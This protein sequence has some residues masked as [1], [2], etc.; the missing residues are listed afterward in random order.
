M[1]GPTNLPT[2]GLSSCERKEICRAHV[3]VIFQLLFALSIRVL[4]II[5]DYTPRHVIYTTSESF[6]PKLFLPMHRKLL[7]P[8]RK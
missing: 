7:T 2:T 4:Y 1:M 3:M 5:I 6:L 8:L